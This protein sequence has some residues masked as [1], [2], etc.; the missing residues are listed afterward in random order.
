MA[1]DDIIPMGFLIKSILLVKFTVI[2]FRTAKQGRAVKVKT[3]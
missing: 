2:A 1:S 3:N